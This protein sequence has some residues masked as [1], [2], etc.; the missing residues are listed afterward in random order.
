MSHCAV[1]W[2]AGFSAVPAA[3]LVFDLRLWWNLCAVR[4]L[5]P[6]GHLPMEPIP[7]EINLSIL[8]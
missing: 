1:C 2:Q 4:S 6:I 8:L 5:M 3:F 7:G